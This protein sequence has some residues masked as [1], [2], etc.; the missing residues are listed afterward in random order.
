MGHPVR[1][2]SLMHFMRIFKENYKIINKEKEFSDKDYFKNI[3][4]QT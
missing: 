3:Y 1:A 2:K 4:L